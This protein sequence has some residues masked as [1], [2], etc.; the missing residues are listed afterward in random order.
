MNTA[1]CIACG[2]DEHHGCPPA[3]CP[4]DGAEGCFWLHFDAE[5]KVGLCSECGDFLHSWK[6]GQR[7]PL[8]SLISVRY[9]RQAM[10]LFNNRESAVGFLATPHELLYGRAPAELI[11]EG[12]LEEVQSLLD[13]LRSYAFV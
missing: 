5:K 1:L 9:Y 12:R 7:E 2:C 10:F 13:Q 6:H 8:L 11:L 4:I 3:L